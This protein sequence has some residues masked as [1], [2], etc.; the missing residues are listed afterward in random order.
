MCLCADDESFVGNEYP[1]REGQH[2][3]DP[4]RTTR[5]SR[6]RTRKFEV[7]ETG[8]YRSEVAG[9]R[10]ELAGVS[11]HHQRLYSLLPEEDD[12]HPNVDSAVV[13]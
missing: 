5:R 2:R 8:T 7:L 11:Q 3:E 12:G 4:N 10:R 6:R 1:S 9:P 13:R